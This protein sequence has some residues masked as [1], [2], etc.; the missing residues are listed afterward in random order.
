MNSKDPT[1]IF[2][3][4]TVT[5]GTAPASFIATKCL[6]ILVESADNVKVK[7]AV[8]SNFYIND[9]LAGV[10]SVEKSLQKRIHELCK[11]A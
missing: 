3:L 6:Q 4:N 1:Q 7:A 9:L 2:E 10:S 11:S 8:Q 5:Y